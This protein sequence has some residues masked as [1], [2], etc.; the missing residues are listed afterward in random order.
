M[1]IFGKTSLIS[2]VVSGCLLGSIGPLRADWRRD[3]EKRILKAEHNLEKEVRKHGENSRQADKRRNDLEKVR[4]Q[5]RSFD[6][7]RR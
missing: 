1:H 2:F 4:E 5:C 6:R 3:C 7:D